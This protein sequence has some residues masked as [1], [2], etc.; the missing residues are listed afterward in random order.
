[1][2]ASTAGR[3]HCPVLP[4]VEH[5]GVSVDLL[6]PP[7]P[8]VETPA[9]NQDSRRL[10]IALVVISAS[11]LMVVLDAT[12]VTI[13]LPSIKSAL[14]FSSVNL[15]W[16]ISA[17][18]L[19]FGGFLLLGGRLGDVFGRRRLFIAGLVV[20]TAASFAG[21]LATT[22]G[23]LIASRAVQGLGGAITAPTA[24]A[25]IGETFP[26]GPSRTR[27]MGIYAAMSGAGGAVG[28]VVGGI[29]TSGLSWRWVFFVNVPIGVL[30]AIAAPRVLARSIR[31]AGTRL[32]V[33]GSVAATAGMT[34]LVYGLVRAPVDGWTDLITYASFAAA[35]VLLVAF[36]L[37]EARS[38][39]PTLPFGLLK[40]RNRSAS[41]IMMF[42]LAGG[43]F[44]VFFFLTQYLQTAKGYSALKAGLA[45]LP[46][47]VAIAGTSQLIARLMR[48]IPPVVLVTVGP[49]M[50]SLGLFWLSRLT[51]HSSYAGGVLGPI[52]VIGVGLGLTFVP[53]VL[54]V[55]SG[56]APAELGIA[57]A[58]LNTA[59]Q[60][61]GTVGLATLVTIAAD[62]TKNALQT[63]SSTGASRSAQE[64]AL[65][66]SLHGY[67]TAFVVGGFI[68]LA[69]FVVAL[70]AVRPPAPGRSV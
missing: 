22:S 12:I 36:V 11:Q 30:V 54:G 10:A 6:D 67:T 44:A 63:S 62:A 35:F 21:G 32:D 50:A 8:V 55:T 39:H 42:A 18:T 33:P 2:T 1:M 4:C 9:A 64:L 49:L 31:Q 37:I 46:F 28:L 13:A 24:L 41:Y 45:F 27:A 25:L 65:A 15:E 17:Y 59:Q 47:S 68:G 23:W 70:I 66:A 56:V 38:D 60:V 7:T 52:M 40:D 58:V 3:R 34:A 26:E 14:H 29:L 48:R 51:V 57:S 53:I 19:V 5:T 20:F 69:A 43:I 16:T 61:G